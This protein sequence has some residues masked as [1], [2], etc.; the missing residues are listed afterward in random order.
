LFLAALWGIGREQVNA[1][2]GEGLQKVA[3]DA[4]AP[5][6]GFHLFVLFAAVVMLL[7]ALQQAPPAGAAEP[8]RY[9]LSMFHFNIQYVAGG[10]EGFLPSLSPDSPQVQSWEID[11]EG[12]EDR[13]ITE[14]FEPIL[15]LYLAHPTWGV[16]LELQGYFLDVLAARHPAVLDKLRS[17]AVSGQ[18]EVVSFHYSDQLFLAFPREDWERSQTLTRETFERYQIPLATT[19]FAQE[20]QAGTG[21]PR[22]MA[23]RGYRVLV[24]PKNLFSYQHGEFDAAPYYKLGEVDMIAGAKG[25]RS[26]V[27]GREGDVEIDVDWTFFGDGETLAS[28]GV[29]PYFTL[30]FI[31]K[32]QAVADYESEVANLEAQGY[33]VSTIGRY[34]DEIRDLGVEPTQAP[35]LLDGTWQPNSTDGIRRWLGAVGIWGDQERDNDVRSL[36]A[37]AHREVVAAQTARAGTDAPG[38]EDAWRLLALSEVS[39]STGIN[40]FRGEVEYGIAHATEA[41]RIARE[42]I[43]DAKSRL[44]AQ[45][46]QI[47]VA[48]GSVQVEPPAPEPGR[49]IAPPLQIRVDGGGRE[50]RES[51][52]ETAPGVARLEVQFSPGSGVQARYLAVTF[53]GDS[54]EIT[55]CPG[56]DDDRPVSIPRSAFSFDHFQLALANGLIGLSAQRFVVKDT[57]QVHLAATVKA[58]NGDV[59]FSDDTA[60]AAD[61]LTWVF[62]IVDGTLDGAVQ[63]ANRLNVSP[64]LVR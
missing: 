64:R 55:Y 62:Y 47:D 51:W 34:V 50:W 30:T 39:D 42:V 40:P 41:L 18:A 27:N 35:P 23:E 31:H 13:I 16:D 36:Q 20:G 48:E 7:V 53:P 24:W 25:V 44:G 58:T 22:A 6:L 52:T 49:E 57:A 60:P 12:V 37:V 38:L 61:R 4:A 8:H 17:L 56:L 32:P 43:D 10:L 2:M 46:V 33:S 54:T 1:I 15:D 9:A 5:R 26:V 28:G 29:D 14:S 45:T 3:G 63:F 19:V 21:V 59:T 11:D